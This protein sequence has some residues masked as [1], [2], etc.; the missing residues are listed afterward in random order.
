MPNSYQEAAS[1]LGSLLLAGRAAEHRSKNSRRCVVG[2]RRDCSRYI[3]NQTAPVPVR[4]A[5]SHAIDHRTESIPF[6]KLK[7]SVW[8]WEAVSGC[9]R[10]LWEAA[11]VTP[12]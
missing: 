12:R 10:P 9:V 7:L 11:H 2:P 6:T 4:A 3:E 1:A 8:P 5:K